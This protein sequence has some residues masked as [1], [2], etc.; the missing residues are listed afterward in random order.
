MDFFLGARVDTY[1]TD[2]DGRLRSCFLVQKLRPSDKKERR[3]H[4]DYWWVR[5]EPPI[6]LAVLPARAA[7]ELLLTSWARGGTLRIPRQSYEQVELYEILD[8]SSLRDG[9]MGP[10]SAAVFG[11]GE[12]ARLPSLLLPSQEQNFERSFAALE[13]FARR[14]GHCNVPVEHYENER[15]LR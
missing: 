4:P 9:T 14:E 1:V 10:E 7:Q 6:T 15:S 5:V 11:V 13:Q 3:T 12:I 8:F 2:I